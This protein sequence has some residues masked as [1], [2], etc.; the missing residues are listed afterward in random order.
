MSMLGEVGKNYAR[1]LII[2]VIS[3]LIFCPLVCLLVFLP[4]WIVN[5]QN[6]N[7]WYLVIPF[8][9]FLLILFGG[10]F[11]ALALTIS[12]RA[13]QLD[14]LFVPLGLTGA[15]YATFF[16]RYSGGFAGRQVRAYFSRG[17]L[18]E[19][20][21]ATPLQTRLSVTDASPERRG[22]ARLF[23]QSMAAIQS[24]AMPGLMAF[25]Q[26][27]AWGRALL[28]HPQTLGLLRSML[29]LQKSLPVQHIILRPGWLRLTL[30]GS[31]RMLAFN[32]DLTAEQARQWLEDLAQFAAIAESLPAPQVTDAETPLE[33]T[34]EKVRNR[35]PYLVP[36]VTV[37]V[38]VGGIFCVS[39]VIIAAVLLLAD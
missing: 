10:G 31:R 17:P 37:A 39:A 16:R 24:P 12:W 32:F 20:E 4:M 35:N 8:G 25:A 27:E 29:S 23:N 1:S 30:F 11:G 28:D 13:R 15:P 36:L 7:A 33:Q 6:L 38:T 26:D 34:A 5:E 18:V 9:L 3:L 22:L 19:I 2:Y 14:A 21:V